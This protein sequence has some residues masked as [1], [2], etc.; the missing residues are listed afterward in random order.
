M[1]K[2]E[3]IKLSDIEKRELEASYNMDKDPS[4]SLEDLIK[5]NENQS[6]SVL[7]QIKN[8]YEW[9]D[10]EDMVNYVSVINEFEKSSTFVELEDSNVDLVIKVF[11]SAVSSKKVKGIALEKV[12]QIYKEFAW[13]QE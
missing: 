3:V 7:R 5:S 6:L 12:V 10:I 11:K 1:K 8:I 13:G 9:D 2:I 4:V